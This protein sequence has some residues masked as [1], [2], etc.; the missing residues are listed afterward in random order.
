MCDV[1]FD[2]YLL[3]C[4]FETKKGQQTKIAENKETSWSQCA[5]KDGCGYVDIREA[6][7]FR[8]QT[9]FRCPNCGKTY[10]FLHIPDEQKD[11]I[12]AFYRGKT[13]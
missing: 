5:G 10:T 1:G 13:K 12:L 6:F 11:R 7:W 9:P 2:Q 8:P 3:P 4:L